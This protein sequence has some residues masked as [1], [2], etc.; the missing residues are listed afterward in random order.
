M[1]AFFTPGGAPCPICC[2][3]RDSAEGH[4]AG[5]RAFIERLWQECAPFVDA[6]ATDHARQDMP[7]VFWELYLAHVL[8]RAGISIMPQQRTKKTQRGPDLFAKNPDVW[9][10]AVVP[11]PGTGQD[12]LKAPQLG[13]VYDIPIEP[14]VL[15]L[16]TVIAVKAKIINAYI[17][18]G[19]ITQG[20][21][22]VIAVSGMLLYS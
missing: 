22:T 21:A 9:I 10:E 2:R 15:R 11:T 14:F 17:R 3:T 6:N 12:G 4:H 13:K 5:G 8:R 19:T 16:R 20:Q 18:D 1:S 7:P